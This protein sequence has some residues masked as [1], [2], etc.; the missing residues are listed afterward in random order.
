MLA[1][2]VTPAAVREKLAAAAGV[3]SVEVEE[4]AP[5]GRTVV[6]VEGEEGADLGAVLYD[7]ARAADWPLRELYPQTRT[8]ESVY[9]TISSGKEVAL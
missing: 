7:Q 1:E 4:D 5:A 2:G 6:L 9:R 8:L 3:Q